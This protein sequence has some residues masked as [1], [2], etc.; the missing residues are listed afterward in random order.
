MVTIRFNGDADELFSKWQHA[1]ELW[2]KVRDSQAPPQVVAVGA[3]GY[4]RD[5]LH[6]APAR[7]PIGSHYLNFATGR[8]V[9]EFNDGGTWR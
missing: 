9:W 2:E 8:P 7:E 5:L 1:V 4:S 6:E 3:A